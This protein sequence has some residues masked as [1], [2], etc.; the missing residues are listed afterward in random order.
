MN[1]VKH[2][3]MLSPGFARDETDTTC[4]TFLQ[5]YLLALHRIHPQVQ[6]EVLALQYP[7]DRKQYLWKGIPVYSAQGKNSKYVRRLFTWIRAFRHLQAL[8]SKNKID[9]IHS[10]WITEASFLAR[11]FSLIYGTKVIAYAIGQDA[12]PT[13]RYLMY[14]GFRKMEIVS[15]SEQISKNLSK[16]N[17]PTRA[18]IPLGVDTAKV[19]A[20][21]PIRK[22]D[23]LGIGSLIP[24]KNY[25]TFIDIVAAL[26]D[27][28]PEIRAELIGEGPERELLQARINALGLGKNIV[29]SGLISHEEVFK[30]LSESRILLHT[31]LSEGQSTVMM[32]ALSAGTHVVCFDV[33]RMD[34]PG[35]IHVCMNQGE[36]TEQIRGLLQTENL[37]HTPVLLQSM[38]SMVN[39]F[40]TVYGS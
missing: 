14:K 1:S 38:E 11:I 39:S 6:T 35:K 16:N 24:L 17:L 40:M 19:K 26:R 2:V 36:M 18:I 10:F 9:V 31:S 22:T 25:S 27:E 28:F 20:G 37:D 15:M 3:V 34:H 12:L 21:S 32:E 30:K 5:D 8:N 29:L 23:L 13:N 4:L 7:F 33:G